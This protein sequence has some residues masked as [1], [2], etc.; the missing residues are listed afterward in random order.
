MVQE[1]SIQTTI[2]SRYAFT[3]VSCAML[4]RRS[5]AAEAVF[6]FQMPANAFVTNFTM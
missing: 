4:N 5:A 2:V 6:Q 3:A 1:L